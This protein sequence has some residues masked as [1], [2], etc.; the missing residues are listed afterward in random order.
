MGRIV[1]P[2]TSAKA[3]AEAKAVGQR[4][5]HRSPHQELCTVHSAAAPR[6]KILMID[7]FKPFHNASNWNLRSTGKGR[8]GGN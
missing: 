7:S 2:V 6:Q 1:S 4:S 5:C 3:T 8:K